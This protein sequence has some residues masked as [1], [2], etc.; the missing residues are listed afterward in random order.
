MP[1]IDIIH[2]KCPHIAVGHTRHQEPLKR[3]HQRSKPRNEESWH[4]KW[5]NYF[6]DDEDCANSSEEVVEAAVAVLKV[7]GAELEGGGTA[8]P[9]RLQGR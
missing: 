7:V 3:K 8:G 2:L 4:S 9:F 1:F 5:K 6:V